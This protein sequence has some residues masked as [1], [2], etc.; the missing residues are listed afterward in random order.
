MT[1]KTN[2]TKSN[3]SQFFIKVEKFRKKC[4]WNYKYALGK[5]DFMKEE[6]TR[7]EKIIEF[8][9][10][11]PIDKPKILDLG[12]G[13]GALNF[14]LKES[15]YSTIT[16]V[17]LS[18]TAI[19]KAKKQNFI[20]SSF[21]TADLNKFNTN[22]HYDIVI[23]N[24]VLYYLENQESIVSRFVTNTDTDYLIISLFKDS[25]TVIDVV[26][27]QYTLLQKEL[28]KQSSEIFWHI[29]LYKIKPRIQSLIVF[30]YADVT[31]LALFF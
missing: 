13:Y 2:N 12:C 3:I 30:F 31:D 29:Y 6:K 8:I 18:S 9:K 14:Y 22:E 16:G 25:D 20:N 17:D 19:C 5:W 27:S 10:A 4:S 28:V 24:E 7:Y 26:P 1:L 23:F 21:I 11:S 15:E